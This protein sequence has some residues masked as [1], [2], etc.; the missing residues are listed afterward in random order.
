MKRIIIAI[1]MALSLV[2][3]GGCAER[4]AD[5]ASRNLSLDADNFKVERRIVFFNG[6][7][8][9]Y[10]LEI[11]GLCSLGN[12]DDMGE[13]SVTCKTGRDQ[14]KKHFLG[15][16]DNVSYFVEQLRA[17][18][19]SGFRYKVIFR[20]EAIVPDIDLATSRDQNSGGDDEVVRGT[21]PQ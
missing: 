20:P 19:V 16:S 15:L 1:L 10:L 3:V 7:T 12:Y 4:E 5:I 14:Y 8:D 6:I 11:R 17:A 21:P 9:T 13:L 18:D 2:F